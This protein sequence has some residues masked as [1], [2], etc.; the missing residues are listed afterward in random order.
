[1]GLQVSSLGLLPWRPKPEPDEILSSWLRRVALGN[2]PKLHS[3]C[4]F[5]WPSRQL[6]TRDLD[7]VADIG[8]VR[9]LASLTGCSLEQ[10]WQ[11]SLH[12]FS[13][14]V[15]ERVQV[16]GATRWVLPLGV[17]HRT[18]RRS[19]Q[20]WCP[21]CLAGD[22]EPYHRRDWRM[23]YSTTC[24]RH[25][26]VLMDRCVECGSP[27][28]PHRTEA[29]ECHVCGADPRAHHS[30][31]AD[32]AVLQLEHSIRA[33]AKGVSWP[34]R[35]FNCNHPLAYFALVRQVLSV[36]TANPRAARLREVTCKHYGGDPRPPV[37]TSKALVPENLAVGE[38][39]RMM[40]IV[41][42]LLRGWPFIFVA[43]CA[44]AGV[45]WSW[46]MRGERASIPY[47]YTNVARWYLH[48]S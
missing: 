12:S 8:F 15:F 33:I 45:W 29:L 48:T 47:A 13:G 9:E 31:T 24:S 10:A 17:Y 20:Q 14:V 35:D 21:E 18:R 36:V 23:A 7:A 22:E 43:M 32:A 4:H 34:G 1:L 38:R 25:G 46:A 39:H 27:A 11:T 3:F 40:A 28:V 41:A 2:S 30:R 19:G 5:I 16:T 6:W 42:K 37:F 44:E 26:T